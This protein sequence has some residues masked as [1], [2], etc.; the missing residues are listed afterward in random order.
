MKSS[1]LNNG[2]ISLF[3]CWLAK[4]LLFVSGW[5]A[6]GKIPDIKKFVIIAAPHS[7]NWDFVFF[8]LVIFKL[9]LP[10]HWMGKK[11]M[12]KWPFAWLLKRLG[13]IPID[14]SQKGNLVQAMVDAF[15]ESAQLMVTIA[16]EG[17]RSRVKYW[18]TGFYHIAAQAGV[19]IALGYIDYPK[20]IVGIGPMFAPTGDIDTDMAEIQAYYSD[21][22]GRY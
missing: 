1:V 5:K 9:R 14:R 15:N 12:F 21:F 10:V 19:P 8:L 22:S 18:K 20:K 6:D 7:T 13:G 16:P 11:T 2:L 3:C 4:F 17:T